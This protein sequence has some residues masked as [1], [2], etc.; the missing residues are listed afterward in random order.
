MIFLSG[1]YLFGVLLLDF[2]I[3]ILIFPIFLLLF[4]DWLLDSLFF[5]V[6]EFLLFLSW[7]I[8]C[9][10]KINLFF[11]LEFG[12][13]FLLIFFWYFDSTF[14]IT[15][16]LILFLLAK[17]NLVFFVLVDIVF[18]ALKFIKL[19]NVFLLLLLLLSISVSVKAIFS[20]NLSFE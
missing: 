18:N 12:D 3:F 1:E 9:V 5:K 11:K 19:L 14:F 15:Y 4:F 8:D 2:S 6:I 16:I 20:P 10:V 17:S 7:E 13:L